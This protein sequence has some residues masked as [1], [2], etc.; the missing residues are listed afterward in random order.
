MEVGFLSFEFGHNTLNLNNF[1]LQFG[2]PS[3]PSRIAIL[4]TD[5]Y[6]QYFEWDKNC[7]HTNITV[8]FGNFV[9]HFLGNI[10]RGTTDPEIQSVT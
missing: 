5:Q 8:L 3:P 2:S 1:V 10:A 4:H 7:P 9:R 6:G